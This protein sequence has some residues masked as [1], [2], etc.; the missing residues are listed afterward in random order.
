MILFS[1]LGR[2]L[3]MRF[4][5]SVGAVF[6]VLFL[7]IYLGDFVEL[8]RRASDAQRASA[9]LLA[10]LA[11]LRTP[12]IAE[13]V[14]PFAVLGGAMFSFIGLSR[15][16][17]LVIARSSGVSVWQFLA[18]PVTIV[19]LIGIAATTLY[20]PISSSLKQKAS[21]IE[22]RVFGR[23]TRADVDTSM[24]IRQRS[25]ANQSIL[26]AERSS[27]GGTRLSGVTAFVYDPQGRFIERVEAQRSVLEPGQW[28]MADA[29]IFVPGED[30]KVSPRY[31]LATGLSPEQVTQ[32]FVHPASVSFWRLPE[33]SRRTEAAGLDSAGYRMQF[34]TLMARPLLLIAMVLIA[35]TVSLRFFRFGGIGQMVSGGVGAGFVLYVA[36]KL[37]GDLGGAGLL[38]ASVAA[39]SP[40]IVG[41]ML[42]TLVLLHQEDG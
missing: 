1:T 6:A 34:Q 5:R 12:T 33:I 24:W 31:I 39:W 36:T 38:S 11:L 16:L 15:R 18:P 17:E 25:V 29:R 41:S 22:T 37:T 13:Q 3:A 14:L 35:A 8:L 40:A 4:L 7:I 30:P 28:I 26:R 21:Q 42:G 32:S 2:Y 9:T 27:D 19:L 10:Y 23:T 20:N